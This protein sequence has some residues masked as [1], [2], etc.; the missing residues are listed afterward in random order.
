[1]KKQWFGSGTLTDLRLQEYPVFLRCEEGILQHLLMGQKGW[2]VEILGIEWTDPDAGVAFDAHTRD[3]IHLFRVDR[4]HW[5]Y[6]SAPATVGAFI[7]VCLGFG[8]QELDRL[9]VRPFGDIVGRRRVSRD[10][11]GGW[12][13]SQQPDSFGRRQIGRAHV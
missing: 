1:M 5:A 8:L 10:G 6:Q 11:Q 3:L 9:T 13:I 2:V 7:H 4:T 12:R